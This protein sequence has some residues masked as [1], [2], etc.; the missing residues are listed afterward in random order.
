MARIREKLTYA[1]TPLPPSTASLAFAVVLVLAVAGSALASSTSVD[2]L[3]KSKVKSLA[4]K[5]IEAAAPGLAVKSS[6]SSQSAITAEFSATAG[7]A[8][9]ADTAKIADLAKTADRAKTADAANSAAVATD[10]G[11]LGGVPPSGYTRPTCDAGNGAVKG[12]AFVD[13]AAP[14][15][16]YNCSGQAVTVTHDATGSYQVTFNGNPAKVAV[17]NATTSGRVVT[18]LPLSPG[19]FQVSISQISTGGGGANSAFS[20]VVP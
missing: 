13:N 15:S 14:T 3:T 16:S 11:S 17:A 2:T 9:T 5:Q 10:A 19:S 8:S 12:F 1:K 7:S 4:D 18:V 6:Q 20:I